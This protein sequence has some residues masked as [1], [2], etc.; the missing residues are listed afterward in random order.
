MIR[1]CAFVALLALVFASVTSAADLVK[2]APERS[3]SRYATVE[4]KQMRIHWN[5]KIAEHLPEAVDF[6]QGQRAGLWSNALDGPGERNEQVLALQWKESIDTLGFELQLKF[7]SNDTHWFINQVGTGTSLFMVTNHARHSSTEVLTGIT[8]HHVSV[9]SAGG[10]ASRKYSCHR[11]VRSC[12]LQQLQSRL[13]W[14][15]SGSKKG[16]SV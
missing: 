12:P 16:V 6:L 9:V 10:C 8:I 15:C 7:A 13:S 2:I 1:I 4:S 3:F 5:P 14:A 11:A